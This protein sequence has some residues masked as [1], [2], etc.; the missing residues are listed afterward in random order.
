MSFNLIDNPTIE[1]NKIEIFSSSHTFTS[2]FLTNVMVGFMI[3]VI[4]YF[5]GGTLAILIL[6]W[7]GFLLAEIIQT[8]Y[9]LNVHVSEIVYGLI[10]HAPTEIFAFLLFGSI[11]L[12][13][14]AFYKRLFKENK[15]IVNDIIDLKVYIKP[16]ALLFI[17]AII[18]SNL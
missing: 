2:I 12:K 1:A 4:G 16:L 15:I 6:F 18:E 9:F 5:S 17:S 10:F 8:S 11:G 7:N 3:S 14:I 13:G